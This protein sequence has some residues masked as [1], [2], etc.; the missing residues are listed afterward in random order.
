[1]AQKVVFLLLL[2]SC[3]FT[4]AQKK[5]KE[6]RTK[7]IAVQNDTITLDSVSINSVQFKVL[8]NQRTT[9]APTEY[10]IDFAKALLVIN[11]KKYPEIIVEYYRFPDFLTKVY[12]PFDE[13]LI[14]PNG[15]NTG[16]LYSLTTNKKPSEIQLFEGLQTKGSISRGVR[17]GNNQNAVTSANLDLQIAGKLSKDITLSANIFDTNIPL[18]QNGYSQN[19]TDFDRIYVALS[20][21]NWE[22]KAGDISFNNQSTFF[23]PMVKQVSGLEV[24]AKLT[25]KLTVGA[26]GAIVRGKFNTHYFTANE[27]NQGPYKILGPNGE[28]AIVII[29]GTET[30]YL[31]GNPLSKEDYS[32]D[33]NLAEI[34]FNTTFPVTNDMRIAIDFQYSDRNYTRFIT[35]EKAEYASENLQINGYFYRENDAKNQPLLQNLTDV[36][37]EILAN[38]GN[39]SSKMVAQSAFEDSFSENKILYRKV[40][41]NG[42]DI[43]EYTTN[44][45]TP[46]FNVTY[47]NVGANNGDYV[48]D[49]SVAIGNIFRYVGIKH[50]D[51]SPIVR[52]IAPIKSQVAVVNTTYKPT[53]KTN[54]TLEMAVSDN[55]QNLFSSL[56]DRNNMGL[57]SLVGWQQVLLDQKWQLKSDVSVEF[58]QN[59]FFTEQGFEP[60][61]FN[62][63]WNLLDNIGD[64]SLIQTALQLQSKENGTL[65]YRF[66]NLNYGNNYKGFKHQVNA[67]LKFNNTR[68]LIDG[69]FLNSTASAQNSTFFRIQSKAEQQFANSWMG[70][71]FG[72]ET[73]DLKNNSLNEF[74]A[75]SHKFQEYETY[76]GIG[77]STKIFAKIGVNYRTNDSIRANR[78]QEVNNRKTLYVN[79]RIVQNKNTNLGVFANYR[80]TQN[81]FKEDEKTLNSKI[82]FNQRLFKNFVNLGTIYETSSGNVPQQD[83]VYVKTEPGFGYYTWL[84]YNNNGIQE[85]NEFEIAQFQDQAEYLRVP[86]PNLRYL[87][88]QRAKINQS[89]TFNFKDWDG[90]QGL[91]QVLSHF[92]NQSFV[93]VE[94]EQERIGDSFLL[95]PFDFNEDKLVSLN[96]SF[97]NSIYFNRNL[98]KNSIT[99]SYG[100]S[101]N[102]QQYLIGNQEN[103]LVSHQLSYQHKFADFWLFDLASKI[104]INELATEN[105]NNRNY[106]INSREIIPKISYLLNKDNRLSAF[107]EFRHKENQLINFEKLQQQ[108]IGVDYY[109]SKNK[110]QVSATFTAF[111][112][113]FTGETNSP[114]A[115]Q[116]LEGLQAGQ[117]FTWSL[118]FNQSINTYLQLNLSYL[119]RKSENSRTIHT[120]NVQLKAIF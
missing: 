23:F 91:K 20:S 77:D 13:R 74:S 69:S 65:S 75:Q 9:I 72:A 29:E 86:L 112:N 12:A 113:D 68:F 28:A 71:L 70:A 3:F 36:Q 119:G 31:Y 2:L 44:D 27:G 106:E 78:F 76:V 109:Y 98:Q 35:Y 60:I 94:N 43:F 1:M 45:T 114:V 105:F 103:K 53:A 83:Y 79:S 41:N 95:N 15:S 50:G 37:K 101:K 46:L 25:K 40:Q 10:Q 93:M 49:R 84:D 16:K 115:Y 107:Y 85:F 64:K 7:R 82:T 80:L 21:K 108:K 96:F 66:N 100:T 4:N 118:L 32:I 81:A 6:F 88:T 54:L 116:M 87:P 104:D 33:Y 24:E 19:I 30:V 14:V 63:D 61:E 18:Q 99:Y 102:K 90:E 55:D 56:D 117:N 92:Y 111:F 26:S 62:R 58:K 120:G 89:V 38:A 67:N 47:T 8:N 51:Y 97:R 110:K 11:A 52:L 57:A 5:P 34:T 59:N 22:V 17:V 73:N 42:V 39:N 48:F